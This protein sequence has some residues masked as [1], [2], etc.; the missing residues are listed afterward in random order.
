MMDQK[1]CYLCQS[2]AFHV[3]TGSVRDNPDLDILECNDC[4]LVYLS[5]FDHVLQ[6]LYED[7]GMHGKQPVDI[8]KWL[9][10]TEVDDERRFQ[11]LKPLLAEKSLLD[12][13]CGAGGF[14]LK[15]QT[16]AAIVYG[17]EIERRLQD[18]FRHNGL[19]VFENLESLLQVSREEKFDIIT[20]FHVLEHLPDPRV[21]LKKLS[22]LLT[23]RGEIVIEVPHADDALLTLYECEAF[24]HFTYW[25]CHLFL[26][27]AKTLTMLAK[28]IGMKINYIKQVQRYPLSNHLYW[29]A[30]GKPGGHKLWHFLD[31]PKSQTA[32]ENMLASIGKCDTLIMSLSS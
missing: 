18:H 7:S 24:S 15:A 23:E 32:Y 31:S 28:Q 3:R 4:G 6:N 19:L 25:S 14:L 20:L 16:G 26:F 5:S 9:A 2:D 27:T 12:F 13:G 17:V 10:N 21:I 1:G 8:D 11:F 30:K 22:T 29:M